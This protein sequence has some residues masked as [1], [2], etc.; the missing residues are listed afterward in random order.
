[1]LVKQLAASGLYV[2]ALYRLPALSE[3]QAENTAASANTAKLSELSLMAGK[4]MWGDRHRG[5]LSCVKSLLIIKC[6]QQS[7][8]A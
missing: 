6:L 7:D 5:A 8:P 1:M 4:G 2:H 3:N